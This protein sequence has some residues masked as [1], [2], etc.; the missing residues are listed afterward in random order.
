MPEYDDADADHFAI[1]LCTCSVGGAA[2]LLFRAP[3]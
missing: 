1:I 3:P 2:W